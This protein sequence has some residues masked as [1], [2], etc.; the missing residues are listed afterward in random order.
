M[1]KNKHNRPIVLSPEQKREIAE[2]RENFGFTRSQARYQV[3]TP[4]QERDSDYR[5]HY[6]YR[7]LLPDGRSYIGV[8]VNPTMRLSSHSSPS[9]RSLI[10][11]AIRRYGRHACHLE[12]LCAG[13]RE[14]MYDL[15]R[16]AIAAF[17]TRHPAGCN[18]DAGG[19]VPEH[20]PE[21]VAKNVASN[22]RTSLRKR[23]EFRRNGVTQAVAI[24]CRRRKLLSPDKRLTDAD[25]S[26]WVQVILAL[27]RPPPPDG[28]CECCGE[29]VG[30]DQLHPDLDHVSGLGWVCKTCYDFNS[31]SLKRR[32]FKDWFASP[33]T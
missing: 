27:M 13:R 8:S 11:Q 23:A 9:T 7:I 4:E 19:I 10:G 17:K 6:L 12:V 1:A 32:K 31:W 29:V 30:T 20:L 22:E 21:S 25:I 5:V 16:R 24:L 2:L 3:L 18:L 26:V 15:E 33:R 28:R 14:H